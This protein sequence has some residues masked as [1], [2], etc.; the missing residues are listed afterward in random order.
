MLTL[1]ELIEYR[2]FKLGLSKVQLRERLSGLGC[3]VSAQ[4]LSN[5]CS[6]RNGIAP[7]VLVPMAKALEVSVAELL[8]APV[9]AS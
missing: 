4:R 5:W 7:G 1:S 8:E 9:R 3:D 2:L 6:G